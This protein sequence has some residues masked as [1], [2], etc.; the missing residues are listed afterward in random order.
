MKKALEG[1][2]SRWSFEAVDVVGKLGGLAISW[3]QRQL[4]CKILWGIQSGIGVD[5]FSKEA[6][7]AFFVWNL[8][9][10]YQLCL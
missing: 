4:R 8:Y 5:L 9:G 3:L 2:L 1:C 7:L 6:N 10:P